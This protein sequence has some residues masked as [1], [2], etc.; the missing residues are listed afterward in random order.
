MR[1]EGIKALCEVFGCSHQAIA[2]WQEQG[3]PVESRGGP[4]TPSVFETADVHAWLVDRAV[5]KHTGGE[6][7]RDRVFRLQGDALELELA[8][9]RGQLIPAAMVEPRWTACC[10][11]ARE[12]LLRAR[13][14]LAAMLDGV[15]DRQQR[16][17]VIGQVHEEFLRKL[18]GWRPGDAV[19]DEASPA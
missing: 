10:V 13:R 15:A 3:M 8:E 1:V 5:A 14:R 12:Q 6:T 18:A 4:N 2:E 17:L 7:Q 19:E 11:A 9:K 16:E